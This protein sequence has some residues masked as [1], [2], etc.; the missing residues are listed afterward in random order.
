MGGPVM[1]TVLITRSEVEGRIVDVLIEGGVVSAVAPDVDRRGRT[2]VD[3][4]GGALLPGL[5]DHH[6][7]LLA[8]AAARTSVRLDGDRPVQDPAGFDDVVSRAH[9]E[10]TTGSWL[11]VTGMSDRHG[12]VDS[13]RLDRLAPGRP[14]RVQHRSGAAWVLSSP[15]LERVGRTESIDGWLHRFDDAPGWPREALD[16]A[17][18]GERLAR[19][20]VTGM[21]DATPFTD[22]E[23][24]TAIADARRS[25]A[26]PQRVMV[27]GAASVA[28]QR[29]PH[30]VDVGPVKVVVSDHELPAIDD[31]VAAFRAARSVGRAVAVHCV[32]RVGL[33]LALTA[34]EEV[35]AVP[36]D[37][38]EH[39]SVIPVE[40]IPRLADLG[41]RVVTQPGFLADRGDRYLAE[42]EADDIAHLYRCGSL[43]EA[44]V[45]VAGSTDAPFGPD[46]PWI[47]IATA[48]D[49]Q[50]PGGSVLGLAEAVEP[51]EA[52]GLFLGSLHDPGGPRRRVVPGLP[53]DLVLLDRPLAA[54]LS[55][56]SSDHVRTTWIGGRLAHSAEG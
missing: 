21:T 52:L 38:I 33:V 40:L 34:W 35:G 28:D 24:A 45:P 3:A 25:N 49:R 16:L 27:T 1:G 17:P 51:A 43:I 42:V 19:L 5:H 48:I 18:V 12:S 55:D 6:L 47:A 39:G 10:L 14:V 11:R 2:V 30:G 7:H 44:G 13:A 31:L 26:I 15:A 9:R 20:G 8:M 56:P 22:A 29:A 36:G 53:A 41:L 54:A 50:I 46:D 23:G 37:R 32:T 4:A